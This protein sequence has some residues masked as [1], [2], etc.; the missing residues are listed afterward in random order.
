MNIHI[1]LIFPQLLKTFQNFL[2]IFLG[3]AIL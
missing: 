1:E 2:M 3:N